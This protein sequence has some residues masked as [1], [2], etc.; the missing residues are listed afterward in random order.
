MKLINLKT[1]LVTAS[2]FQVCRKVGSESR[3]DADNND[4]AGITR[5]RRLLV[6]DRYLGHC[7]SAYRR[8]NWRFCCQGWKS[9]ASLKCLFF[10]KVNS[11]VISELPGFY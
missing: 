2:M 8:H 6:L 4:G 5:R 11:D 3:R 10:G 7:R 1:R 9:G